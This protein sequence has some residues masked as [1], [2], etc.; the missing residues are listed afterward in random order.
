MFGFENQR[1]I[2]VVPFDEI[3]KLQLL[4]DLQNPT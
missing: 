2:V 3:M 4:K 1:Y